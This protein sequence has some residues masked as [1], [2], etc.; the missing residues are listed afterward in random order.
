[1]FLEKELELIITK[2]QIAKV[3]TRS[4]IALGLLFASM[5]LNLSAYFLSLK[6]LVFIQISS[7]VSLILVIV[8]IYLSIHGL[9]QLGKY[10][11]M[12]KD[13]KY[14]IALVINSLILLLIFY[15]IFLI[16]N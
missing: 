15:N 14:F 13:K 6:Y 2:Q 12:P 7:L 1:M 10:R 5:V 9:I 8:T 3:H 16:I 11:K 4:W